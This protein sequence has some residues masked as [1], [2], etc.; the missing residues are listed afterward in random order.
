ML[1]LVE[2]NVQDIKATG[3]YSNVGAMSANVRD[4]LD[5]SAL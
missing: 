1:D 2:E 3:K 4:I 5:L